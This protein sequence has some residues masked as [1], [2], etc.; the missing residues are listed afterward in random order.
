MMQF[1]N[2]RGKRVTLNVSLLTSFEEEVSNR[3]GRPC[4]AVVMNGGGGQY[5]SSHCIDMPY[6]QFARTVNDTYA[7]SQDEKEE[8]DS[9]CIDMYHPKLTNWRQCMISVQRRNVKEMESIGW[10]RYWAWQDDG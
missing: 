1:L 5:I 4:T 9:L 7:E 8:E 10:E 3:D 6:D 2:T